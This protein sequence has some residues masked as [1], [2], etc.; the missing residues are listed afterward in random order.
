L[1]SESSR[2]AGKVNNR[3]KSEWSTHATCCDFK[4]L[5]E[6]AK[7]D[8]SKVGTSL[9][10]TEKSIQAIRQVFEAIRAHAHRLWASPGLQKNARVKPL[11]R[12]LESVVSNGTLSDW[13]L[14]YDKHPT[15]SKPRLLTCLGSVKT[16]RVQSLCG[17]CSGRS[18]SFFAGQKALITCDTCRHI[19]A[20]CSQQL[21]FLT[22]YLLAVRFLLKQARQSELELVGQ[23]GASFFHQQLSSLMSEGIAK[24]NSVK[25][26]H[27]LVR[28][29]SHKTEENQIALCE[30][31]VTL[32]HKSFSQSLAEYFHEVAQFLRI[33]ASSLQELT[34]RI[35]SSESWSLVGRKRLLL[36]DS[37]IEVF[38]S[39]VAVMHTS[40]KLPPSG[41][42]F[43]SQSIAVDSRFLGKVPLPL[44]ELLRH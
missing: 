15:F 29:H 36:S 1:L 26:A 16:T 35:D 25:F 9:F 44:I 14:R 28:Y 21:V 3:C 6:Y 17:I 7:K 38:S 31:F 10:S 40:V 43:S 32:V 19:L 23:N 20:D 33:I 12:L 22:E 42:S 27:L 5:E 24:I 18:S 4:S 8:Y 39:D 2:S 41:F 30:A 37:S 13:L 11:T 34:R